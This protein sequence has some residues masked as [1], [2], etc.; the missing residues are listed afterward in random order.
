VQTGTWQTQHAN[1][2][3][4]VLDSHFRLV[5]LPP[6]AMHKAC[7]FFQAL[8]MAYCTEPKLLNLAQLCREVL[9]ASLQCGDL[10]LH[11]N[12]T[13][14]LRPVVIA[15]LVSQVLHAPTRYLVSMRYATS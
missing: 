3:L 8:L 11:D 9:V 12:E 1:L 4:D 7:K 6:L 13:L 2:S 5:Q 10:L 15:Q 14:R